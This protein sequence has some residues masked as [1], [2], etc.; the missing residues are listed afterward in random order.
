MC[1]F[2]VCAQRQI[3]FGRAGDECGEANV[4]C[5]PCSPRRSREA[6]QPRVAL[7]VTEAKPS[8]GSANG[9][10]GCVE[11]RSGWASRYH[12]GI[13][14]TPAIWRAGVVLWLAGLERFPVAP[15]KP[16]FGSLSELF[17]MAQQRRENGAPSVQDC[18]VLSF[19][20]ATAKA[21]RGRLPVE[22]RKK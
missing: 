8:G 2:G 5:G 3:F 15:E 18:A 10:Q 17:C 11:G 20:T 4:G 16:R 1:P 9:V 21:R 7:H 13:R 19:C 22:S 12:A 6:W 14:A